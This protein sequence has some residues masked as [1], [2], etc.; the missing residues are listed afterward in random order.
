MDLP[1]S[2]QERGAGTKTLR[3]LPP[4]ATDRTSTTLSMV[5]TQADVSMKV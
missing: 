5:T 2:A 3:M 4:L 1:P